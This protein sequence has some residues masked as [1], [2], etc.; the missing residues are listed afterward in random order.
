M[1]IEEH[2]F[3]TIVRLGTHAEAE[4]GGSLGLLV[5][6]VGEV[7]EV[8][9]RERWI[10]K[11]AGAFEGGDGPAW[12]EAVQEMAIEDGLHREIEEFMAAF[13]EH[14]TDSPPSA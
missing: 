4:L 11:C 5:K 3:R 2:L 8:A 7:F 9:T 12:L 1:L 14:W 10:E 13:A 6:L